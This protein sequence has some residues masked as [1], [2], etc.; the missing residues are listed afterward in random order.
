MDVVE[1]PAYL[2]VEPSAAAAAKRRRLA[3]P[4]SD[5][6]SSVRTRSQRPGPGAR[7]S[8]P[9]TAPLPDRNEPRHGV[10]HAWA[11]TGGASCVYHH[12]V[13]PNMGV[14]RGDD[15]PNQED[16]VNQSFQS[17]TG[18]CSFFIIS[19]FSFFYL[20]ISRTFVER[21]KVDVLTGVSR[22]T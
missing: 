17:Q 18:E 9:H 19:L 12:P 22:A 8:T 10:R 11:L 5:R 3:F 7:R 1:N 16:L 2:A 15:V 6:T 20:F 14:F 13:S 21:P 4:F